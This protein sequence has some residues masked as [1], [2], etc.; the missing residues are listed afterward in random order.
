MLGIAYPL[1]IVL[2]FQKCWQK[3]ESEPGSL[4]KKG[5]REISSAL[6]FRFQKHD[7]L[8]GV[9]LG[10]KAHNV[11]SPH[12]TTRSHSPS[13]HPSNKTNAP[14]TRPMGNP[15]YVRLKFPN[16]ADLNKII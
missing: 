1:R 8:C 2:P 3:Q 7:Y 14:C 16:F 6:Y 15:N 5:W 10:S 9:K 4:Q 13:W 11:L 12:I